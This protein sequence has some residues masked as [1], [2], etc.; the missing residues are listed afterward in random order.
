MR[1][2][3]GN[4]ARKIIITYSSLALVIVLVSI[5]SILAARYV[6]R[7]IIVEARQRQESALLSARI[8]SEALLL[9]NATQR[10]VVA[11]NRGEAERQEINEQVTL[12]EGLLKQAI[13]GVDP[14]DLDESIA[15]GRVRELLVAF[16]VQSRYVLDTSDAE[17]GLGAETTRQMN[18][19]LN[20]YQPALIESLETFEKLERDTAEEF[21]AQAEYYAVRLG[22]ILIILSIAS[23]AL[24][25]AMS[26]W[27]VRH[28]IVP[29]T[30]LTENVRLVP[31]ASMN[32]PV[33][34]TSNDE[35]GALAQAL[36]RMKSEINE[37]R[38]KLEQYAATL[39]SQVEERTRELKLLAITDPLTG[40][41]NRGHFFRLAEQLFAEAK[42]LDHPFSVAIFDLDHFKIINDHYG[43]AVGD[44]ALKQATQVMQSQIRQM[45]VLGRYGGEEFVV[46]LPAAGIEDALQIAQRIAAVIREHLF[47]SDG[48]HFNITIS[49][50][51][52]QRNGS[53]NEDMGNIMLKADKALYQAKEKG[54]DM[55]VAYQS[56][57]SNKETAPWNILPPN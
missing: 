12:L 49:G 29:L 6:H 25:A 2:L 43:H 4:I 47:E 7:A 31:D 42:R 33:N 20:H 1:P 8:R 21:V 32:T 50:G 19:L 26:F 35:M 41:Y 57:L 48:Q 9:T 30:A 14:S 5:G 11:S 40:A 46:A 45:D 53:I 55:I 16:K 54:R 15:L 10:Y 27:L 13:K 28:F 39:E 24:V 17:G 44:Q 52:A 22:I 34:I 23:I 51:I 38:Q 37:S 3:S 18:I 56:R 36:N